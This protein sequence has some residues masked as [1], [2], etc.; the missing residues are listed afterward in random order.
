V[1]DQPARRF[2]SSSGH[3]GTVPEARQ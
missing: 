1:V 3:A 2:T